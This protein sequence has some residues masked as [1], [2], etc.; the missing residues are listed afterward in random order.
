VRC[1]GFTSHPA[2]RN[3]VTSRSAWATENA[4]SAIA[5]THAGEPRP[6]PRAVTSCVRAAS[7]IVGVRVGW[8]AGGVGVPGAAAA[9]PAVEGAAA[10]VEEGTP[11]R[12]RITRARSASA[13]P[14]SSTISTGM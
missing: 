3:A 14:R 4:S 6:S 11:A 13:P 9:L 1:K 5:V 8:S 7:E 10:T 12:L 2:R